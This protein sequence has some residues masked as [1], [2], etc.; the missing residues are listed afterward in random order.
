M[1]K[2]NSHESLYE[3]DRGNRSV[4][5]AK[6][7]STESK[8]LD[9][10]ESIS[11][12]ADGDTIY[13]ILKE[14][15]EVD[16]REYVALVAKIRGSGPFAV[17]V[18]VILSQN[19]SDRNSI[20]AFLNL[21]KR[22]GTSLEKILRS[23]VKEIEDAIKKAGLW[24]QKARTIK[25]AAEAIARMGGEEYL[26]K[27]DPSRLREFLTSIDGIGYKT[28]DVFLSVVRRAPYF[29]VDTHAMRIA[30]RWG[31]ASKRS[32]EE[33]SKALLEFFGCE[34]AEEAHRLLIALGRK[35]CRP[36][37]PKCRECPVNMYCPAYRRSDT[38]KA[39]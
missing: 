28:A 23:D 21:E 6:R 39:S 17:L 4:T 3:E 24:R 14:S 2:I 33:A 16:W 36:R 27:E 20:E 22:V 26:L 30:I 31:L 5:S 9:K 37:N 15:L 7:S 8:G 19:T 38:D 13:R 35:Y 29:A 10:S 34:R 11:A 25:R 18:G 32:Y 12:K 1:I